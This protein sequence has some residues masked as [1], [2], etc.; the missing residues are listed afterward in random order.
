MASTWY[1]CFGLCSCSH[2]CLDERLLLDLVCTEGRI[3]SR[4]ASS[5]LL[6]SPWRGRANWIGLLVPSFE[7]DTEMH[8]EEEKEE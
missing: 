1:E 7:W 6:L 3:A 2:G 8:E 4:Y 5:F